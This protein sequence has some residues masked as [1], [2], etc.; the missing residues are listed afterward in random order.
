M[1]SS[2]GSDAPDQAEAEALLRQVAD[3]E[4]EVAQLRK[5]LSR[6]HRSGSAPSRSA[7]S[8][9]RASW[10]RPCPRTRS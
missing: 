3:L 2:D 10:P 7:C 6:T 5:R 1:A 9:P 8:R 4:D